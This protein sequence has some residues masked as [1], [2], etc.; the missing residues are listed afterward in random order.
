MNSLSI[1]H[2]LAALFMVFGLLPLAFVMPVMWNKFSDM[3]NGAL[4]TLET[5]A[6]KTGEI[7]DRNLQQRYS[8]VQAFAAN[9]ASR[10]TQYW[11][12]RGE[13]SPLVKA[14]NNYMQ[15]YG[16]YKLMMLVDMDGKVAAVNSRDAKGNPLPSAY[17][18][19]A[20][21]ANSQWFEHA[22]QRAFLKGDGVDGAV[23]EAPQYDPLVSE[24]YAG[25]D[26]F[27]I[28]FAAPVYDYNNQMIGVWV[29]F[30]DFAVVEN[31]VRSV[32]LEQSQHSPSLAI[33]VADAQGRL[34]VDFDPALQG[35]TTNIQRDPS[36]IGKKSVDE[37]GLPAQV[38]ELTGER[39]SR[40]R[41]HEASG[42]EDA[43]GWRRADGAQG[44][45]GLGW[46]VFVHQPAEE[47]FKAVSSA[48][49]AYAWR[50]QIP[51]GHGSF[52]PGS[53]GNVLHM[54]AGNGVDNGNGMLPQDAWN[55][56]VKMDDGKP[57]TGTMRSFLAT[58][59]TNCSSDD[60]PTVA[61]YRLNHTV[62][63]CLPIFIPGF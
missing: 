42:A 22:I 35:K 56:D 53:Y 18:Y 16:A 63:G 4:Q 43:V 45:P 23:V 30:V 6:A 26:G 25:E 33:G 3:Q 40:V 36:V 57:G 52:Y 50:G 21:L 29:N 61:I 10:D 37:I 14:M 49:F 47:A 32:Y 39:G 13:A 58:F 12:Q 38:S 54:G 11:Y 20:N 17:A 27:T 60:D 8:D 62:A 7:I 2:K 5:T 48:G 15:H 19:E 41:M 59:R 1:S 44:F 24:T 51:T 34:L 46:S 28:P 31:I 55:I 9:H